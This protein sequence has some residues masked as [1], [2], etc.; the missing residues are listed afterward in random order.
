[1]AAF[2]LARC[3]AKVQHTSVADVRVLREN[4]KR[5]REM[6]GEEEQ[7]ISAALDPAERRTKS[8]DQDRSFQADLR[9]LVRLLTL[10]GLRLGEAV[11]LRWPNVDWRAEVVTLRETKA[12]QAQHFPLGAEALAILGAGDGEGYI[13]AWSNGRPWAP[14][15]V[16]PSFRKAVMKAG[17]LDVHAHDLRHTFACRLLRGG[18]DIYAVSKLLRNRGHERALCPSIAS[19]FEGCHGSWQSI[20]RE[21]WSTV[22]AA[23]WEDPV[24]AFLRSARAFPMSL[25]VGIERFFHVQTVRLSRRMDR[26]LGKGGQRGYDP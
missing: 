3:N 5:V 18:V 9:L 4:N 12:G 17:L 10:T 15:Y 8:G 22:F 13:F 6:R 16:T 11:N 26:V 20:S 7:A 23:A 25:Q 19:G 21:V 2:N 24:S 14:G 1:M